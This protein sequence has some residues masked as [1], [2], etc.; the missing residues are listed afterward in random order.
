MNNGNA[1]KSAMVIPGDTSTSQAGCSAPEMPCAEVTKVRKKW[2]K[3]DRLARAGSPADPLD[4]CKSACGETAL[5]SPEWRA[6]LAEVVG[7][8]RTEAYTPRRHASA[9]QWMVVHLRAMFGWRDPTGAVAPPLGRSFAWGP[10]PALLSEARTDPLRLPA[11]FRAAIVLARNLGCTVRPAA[12][13]PGGGPRVLPPLPKLPAPGCLAYSLGV[14]GGI[15]WEILAPTDPGLDW[16]ALPAAQH[17]ALNA[18]LAQALLPEPGSRGAWELQTRPDALKRLKPLLL[19]WTGEHA[20]ERLMAPLPG[21]R[22]LGD[23]RRFPFNTLAAAEARL[24]PS[25]VPVFGELD[26][27]KPRSFEVLPPLAP[28]DPVLYGCRESAVSAVKRSGYVGPAPWPPLRDDNAEP[29]PPEPS[30]PSIPEP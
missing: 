12:V 16:S 22:R 19:W 24:V 10:K 2:H 27:E 4:S 6:F 3:R 30:V 21:T 28:K 11:E 7:P 26:F 23:G 1:E 5:G 8:N 18:R 25:R 14:E 15:G 9:W 29:W 20:R 17:A 13:R